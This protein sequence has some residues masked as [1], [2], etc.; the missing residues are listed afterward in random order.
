M[1]NQDAWLLALATELAVIA[2]MIWHLPELLVVLGVGH[3]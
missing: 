3:G 2:I 1:S